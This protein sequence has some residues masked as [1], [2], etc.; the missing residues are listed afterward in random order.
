M[1]LDIQSIAEGRDAGQAFH[2]SDVLGASAWGFDDNDT[3]GWGMGGGSG[4]Y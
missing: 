1:I 2:V 4:C 3:G